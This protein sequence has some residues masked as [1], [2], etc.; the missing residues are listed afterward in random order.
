MKLFNLLKHDLMILLLNWITNQ[1]CIIDKFSFRV[2]KR[3]V[4]WRFLTINLP[5]SRCRSL[6]IAFAPQRLSA[7]TVC[8]CSVSC[9]VL[10]TACM[11]FS[12][13]RSIRHVAFVPFS[14]F[15]KDFVCLRVVLKG[16]KVQNRSCERF[17]PGWAVS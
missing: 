7:C 10:W 8:C 11:L 2:P 15:V 12:C 1:I 16:R 4:W 6:L 5:D 14:T 3:V 17:I 13:C 9:Y